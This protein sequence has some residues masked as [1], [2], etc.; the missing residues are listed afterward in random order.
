MPLR[1]SFYMPNRLRNAVCMCVSRL[2]WKASAWLGSRA[3][4]AAGHRGVAE[5]R[6]LMRLNG[7][8]AYPHSIGALALRNGDFLLLPLY[9]WHLW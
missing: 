6:G 8:L 9:F 3:A 7:R 4:G 2:A 1:Q 5:R